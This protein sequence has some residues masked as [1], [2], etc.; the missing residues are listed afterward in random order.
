MLHP[1]PGGEGRL[2][3]PADAAARVARARATL[4]PTAAEAEAE[5]EQN[6]AHV[7]TAARA[8]LPDL[9]AA[10]GYQDGLAAALL[11][12]GLSLPT[13]RDCA[14]A[15]LTGHSLTMPVWGENVPLPELPRGARVKVAPGPGEAVEREGAV[16]ARVADE[17]DEY[18]VLCAGASGAGRF[19]RQR[20]KLSDVESRAQPEEGL[21]REGDGGLHAEGLGAGELAQAHEAICAHFTRLGEAALGVSPRAARGRSAVTVERSG[22]GTIKGLGA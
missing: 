19:K 3:L 17:R 21:A 15:G 6:A 22:V 14:A 12:L 5:L 2:A 16:E 10:R 4:D 9:A 18:L 7:Q 8:L 1:R 20:L 13:A 11:P